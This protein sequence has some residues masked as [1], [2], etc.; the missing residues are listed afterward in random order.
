MAAFRTQFQRR[1]PLAFEP[2]YVFRGRLTRALDV[3]RDLLK[4]MAREELTAIAQAT[5]KVIEDTALKLGKEEDAALLGDDAWYDPDS[6][7]DRYH[8]EQNEL[9]CA[10][11]IRDDLGELGVFLAADDQLI[12]QATAG[13]L[14][15]VDR[16]KAL[17]VMSLWLSM[18]C[19]D[20]L[21]APD[22]DEPDIHLGYHAVSPEE[23]FPE[24]VPRN[25]PGFEY[26]TVI[27][28][29]LDAMRASALALEAWARASAM[30]ASGVSP[31]IAAEILRRDQSLQQ[32]LSDRA[33]KASK[34]R[35][36]QKEELE[37]RALEIAR[38]GNFPSF[39]SAARAIQDEVPKTPGGTEV[40]TLET[41]ESWLKKRKWKPA[42]KG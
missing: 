32:E 18:D 42:S 16:W 5:A 39:A 4:G 36:R 24:G 13:K 35:W 22:D 2:G 37:A 6:E 10:E 11:M 1:D 9:Q 23:L 26:E 38:A 28:L 40:Y 21:H 14:R 27:V 31:E 29:A 34:A 33:S 3:S 41:I 7:E 8:Q 30:A 17:A 20:A 25:L 19:I 12:A 15:A